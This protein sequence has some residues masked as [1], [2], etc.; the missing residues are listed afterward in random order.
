[1]ARRGDGR[2]G[3]ESESDTTS[4]VLADRTLAGEAFRGCADSGGSMLSRRAMVQ[5]YRPVRP[6]VP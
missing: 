1:M 6:T 2:E 3:I 4:C 5:W